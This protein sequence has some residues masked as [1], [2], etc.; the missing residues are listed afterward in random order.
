MLHTQI[1]VEEAIKARQNSYSPYSKFMVGAALLSSDE[2]IYGGCNIECAAYSVSNCAERT[3]IFRAVYDGKKHFKAIAVVGG[4]D[5]ENTE[6]LD[7][8]PPC[9][10]CR[11]LLREFCN[12][13]DFKVILAKSIDD[14]KIFTLEDLLPESFGP[15][16]LA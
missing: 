12:P 4:K 8:C 3:A 5:C 14:I 11:Q 13:H 15:E 16:N 1:L 6:F 7:Y 9:G 10:V 2:K